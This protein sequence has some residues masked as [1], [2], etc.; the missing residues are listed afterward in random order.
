[1]SCYASTTPVTGCLIL[2]TISSAITAVTPL[3][4]P[5]PE[6]YWKFHDYKMSPNL[7]VFK[8]FCDALAY[9]LPLTQYDHMEH[10]YHYDW[11]IRVRSPVGA[12]NFSLHHCD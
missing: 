7:L 9:S 5:V 6:L 3:S 2:P 8:F 1:M 4:F 10:N 12:G 11:M